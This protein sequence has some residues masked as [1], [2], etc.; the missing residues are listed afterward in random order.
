MTATLEVLQA[1][2]KGCQKIQGDID[3]MQ[4]WVRKWQIKSNL[5]K[6]EDLH[7]GQLE[8]I[9]LMARH[10]TA[11]ICNGILESMFITQ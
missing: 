10:L 11:L 1:V 5:S 9:Q 2:S 4:K 3:Q 6:C 7:S 8:S